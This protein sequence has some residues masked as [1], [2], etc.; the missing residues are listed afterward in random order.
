MTLE[1]S[2]CS[3]DRLTL[4]AASPT[5]PLAARALARH[6]N[7]P[8]GLALD[9]LTRGPGL[10]AD[11]L[12]PAQAA[13]LAALLMALGLR[14]RHD[15]GEG[16]T[17]ARGL[18]D[19]SLQLAPGAD[20][21]RMAQ[22]LAQVLEQPLSDML[23]ALHRPG[24]VILT[25]P[26]P[27]VVDRLRRLMRRHKGLHLATSC[28]DQAVHDLFG[29]NTSTRPQRRDLGRHLRLLGLQP[30]P[31]SGAL[32]A[33]LDRRTLD[34]LLRRFAPAGVFGLN[35]AFQRF[36]L[37]LTASRD[38]G[39]RALQ[40]FLTTRQIDTDRLALDASPVRID[41]GLSHAAARQFQSDYEMIG[42]D[43]FARLQ[44]LDQNP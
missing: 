8:A 14:V 1:I 3:G 19:L 23:G 34:H 9:R 10:L 20:R 35:R 7:I 13:R 15:R 40:D 29:G 37:F 32:A 18:P 27:D 39:P 17:V 6:L 12:E 41:S 4:L 30:C 16:P 5:A 26:Q 33:G 24:G 21:L 25:A 2:A 42:L 22:A 28:P 31:F 43:T 36:D 44:A 11:G 38:M